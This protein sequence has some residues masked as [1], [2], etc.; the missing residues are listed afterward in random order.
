MAF[1]IFG[2]TLP[3][4]FTSIYRSISWIYFFHEIINCFLWIN[5]EAI[6]AFIIL[7]L[8]ES[9]IFLIRVT[10]LSVKYLNSTL[11]SDFFGHR[12]KYQILTKIFAKNRN[13]I[14]KNVISHKNSGHAFWTNIDLSYHFRILRMS[15]FQEMIQFFNNTHVRNAIHE[16]VCVIFYGTDLSMVYFLFLIILS[17]CA[18]VST[19]RYKVFIHYIC[20]TILLDICFCQRV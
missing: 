20:Y 8:M 15:T 2:F 7:K 11:L 5:W 14:K 17:H 13:F 10:V 19:S 4:I 16:N 3:N 6:W 9:L 12:R 18:C 1:R